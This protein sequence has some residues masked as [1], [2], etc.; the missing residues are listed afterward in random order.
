MILSAIFTMTELLKE[1]IAQLQQLPSDEQNAIAQRLLDELEEIVAIRTYDAAK[2]SQDQVI[3]FEQ[4]IHEI[5]S[6]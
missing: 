1:A 2:Q 4:A 3:S 6:K 5:E